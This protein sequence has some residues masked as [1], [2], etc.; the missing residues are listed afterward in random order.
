MRTLVKALKGLFKDGKITKDYLLT[1][2]ASGL[3]SSKE[4]EYIVG[5]PLDR[6]DT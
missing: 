3:I 4:Y 1:R 2:V 6:L 5:E